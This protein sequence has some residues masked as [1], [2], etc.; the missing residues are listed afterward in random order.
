MLRKEQHELVTMVISV[1]RDAEQKDIR[2]IQDAYVEMKEDGTPCGFCATG[3]IY[4][5]DNVDPYDLTTGEWG[6]GQSAE[7]DHL[8]ILIGDGDVRSLHSLIIEMNDDEKLTFGQI[9]DRLEK[10]FGLGQEIT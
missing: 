8:H 10:L 9:A 7:M 4:Y 2:Q 1:L 5:Q 6:A 3:Y